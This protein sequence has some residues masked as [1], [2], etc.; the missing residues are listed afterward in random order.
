MW[1]QEDFSEA[2]NHHREIARDAQMQ[3]V[4]LPGKQRHSAQFEALVHEI[5]R[6][7]MIQRPRQRILSQGSTA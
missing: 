2:M 5:V 7:S 6:E 4:A 1:F 3:C